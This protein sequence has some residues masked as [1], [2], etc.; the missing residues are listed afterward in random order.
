MLEPYR[1]A[2]WDL[3]FSM[4]AHASK[5]RDG[6]YGKPW[7]IVF[8]ILCAVLFAVL[9]FARGPDREAHT[10]ILTTLRAVD[11]NHASLQRDVLKA[12]AGLIRNYDPLVDSVVY[13][14]DDLTKL[15]SLLSQ[16]DV[17]DNGDLRALLRSLAYSVDRDEALVEEFKTENAL[18][19][20]SLGIFS[21]V[22]GSLHRS[23]YQETQ[24][25]VMASDDLGN[26]MM[27]FSIQPNEALAQQIRFE[28]DGLLQSNAAVVPEL[29]TLVTHGRMILV[30][31]PP[32]D[33]KVLAIQASD[34]SSRA[35]D[36]QRKYLEA[37]DVVSSRSTLSRMFL[38]SVSVTL[39]GY[40]ALL[41]Y[42]LRLQTERLK[43]RLDFESMLNE[44]KSCF[45]SH[46]LQDCRPAVEESLD[47]IAL[48]FGADN[49]ELVLLNPETGEREEVYDS[50][51]TR[52]PLADALVAEFLRETRREHPASAEAGQ[53][54][55]FR[56]LQRRDDLAFTRDAT[57]AGVGIG[58]EISAQCSGVLIL[59]F[60]E[61][62]KKANADEIVLMKGA[63]EMVMRSIDDRRRRLDRRTLER[64]LEHAERLQ[65]VGTLAGGI[66]HE[67]NNILAAILGYGEMA[68]QILRRPSLT[69]HYVQEMV[70]TGERATQIIDQIL[71]LSRKSERTSKPFSIVEAVSDIVP[72]LKISLPDTFDLTVNLSEKPSVILGS[73]I[74]IQQILM[75]LCKNAA[76]ASGG[77]GKA[78]IEV[79]PI[80][81][82]S[83]RTL[84]HGELPTGNYILMSV[85]D[86]GG[87]IPESVLP[88]IFEPFFT[89]KSRSGGTG[90]GLAAVHGNIVG[91]AGKINV[92]S[93]IGEGTRFELYFPVSRQAPI[94]LR[95][96]F[97]EQSVP[98][99]EGQLV[100][101]L[102]GEA[103]LLPMYEEKLA[104]LGYEPVGFSD[105]DAILSWLKT[106]GR[107]PDLIMLDVE[108]LESNVT[109]SDLD[110]LFGGIPYLLVADQFT[111]GHIGE[112]R[113]RRAG[114]LKKPVSSKSMAS[115][116]YK[117]INTAA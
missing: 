34:T 58:L 38:G 40:I 91:L 69:K 71:A 96:F 63:T 84:S 11:L 81:I 42:R 19:Q 21:Q 111:G 68:L 80:D 88:H 28:L 57:S 92:E 44:I 14:H 82:R 17:D 109:T 104:A 47:A 78:E 26:M 56:N 77:T 61:S 13:L 106:S 15:R 64:R 32:V 102:E 114:I 6:L 115:A 86:N 105:L 24:R 41:V 5:R 10:A 48:F 107:R 67:F 93:R 39:C 79:V 52:I 76:E 18:L 23:P 89:T 70:S 27:R 60:A 3:D 35:Q 33:D 25:A 55:F 72:L 22:L 37:Y 29:G 4:T 45:N 74:E 16:A 51:G 94:P 100:V 95:Q 12:R 116:I 2:D 36:L 7:G 62:R 65:A 9:A 31:L 75:N 108:S 85:A 110:R 66:A 112:H 87:G 113:L 46:P 59:E 90:L 20:N 30:T 43:R 73:P 97:N 99:G 103:A 1:G 98:L 53:R 8:A 101:I 49:H 83:R 50:A 54:F 117:K